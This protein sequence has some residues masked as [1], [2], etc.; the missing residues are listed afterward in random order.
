VV[1][2]VDLVGQH[3][4]QQLVAPVDVHETGLDAHGQQ[5]ERHGLIERLEDFPVGPAVE[6]RDE[7][8]V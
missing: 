3:A 7:R 8:G 5:H 1:L 6:G 4:D 2:H